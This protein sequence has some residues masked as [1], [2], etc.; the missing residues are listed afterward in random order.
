MYLPKQCGFMCRMHYQLVAVNNLA[1]W[2]VH[3]H[4]CTKQFIITYNY[5][6]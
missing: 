5:G 1:A 6:N 4:S 2:M 3:M